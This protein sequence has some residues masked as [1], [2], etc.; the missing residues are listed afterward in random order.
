M[1]FLKNILRRK[2]KPAQKEAKSSV[3]L[4]KHE[5]KSDS[6]SGVSRASGVRFGVI[7]A[8]RITE[9]SADGANKR[10]YTFVVAPWATKQEVKKMV[11]ARYR[12]NV[13]NVRVVRLPGKE[14]RRGNQIGF[15][16]G[17]K[18]AMV[19]IKEGQTIEIQ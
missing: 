11:E 12:V 10:A 14:R 8:S 3:S 2:E 19:T 13:E 16:P 9:K 4:A 1:A 5:E 7:I 15:K 6:L 18:K 17:I